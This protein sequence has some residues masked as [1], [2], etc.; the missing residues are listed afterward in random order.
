MSAAPP[1]RVHN[2]VVE[3]IVLIGSIVQINPRK[4][5]PPN[6]VGEHNIPR[7]G[8]PS[9]SSDATIADAMRA[10]YELCA[11]LLHSTAVSGK[12]KSNRGQKTS[13]VPLFD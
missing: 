10:A 2:H 3:D 4:V 12:V 1:L 7:L 13:P 6:Q 8:L 5:V 9:S 11:A